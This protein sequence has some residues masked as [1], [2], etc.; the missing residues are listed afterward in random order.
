MLVS[1]VVIQSNSLELWGEFT[2]ALVTVNFLSV[3]LAFGNKDYLVRAFSKHP[4]T[5]KSQWNKIF[6]S[7]IPILIF[8]VTCLYFLTYDTSL[9][10]ICAVWLTLNFIQQS[11]DS[12]VLF[13]KN[14]R[15]TLLIELLCSILLLGFL[16]YFGNKITL[17]LLLL[18]YAGAQVIRTLLLLGMYWAHLDFPRSSSFSLAELKLLTPFFLLGLGGFLV[19]KADL[20]CVSIFLPHSEKASYQII[21]NLCN[22]GIVAASMVLVPFTKNI[23]RINAATFNVLHRNFNFFGALYSLSFM[24]GVYVLCNLLFKIEFTVWV[25]FGFLIN[26]FAFTLFLPYMFLFTK[27]N[28]QSQAVYLMLASGVFTFLLSALL[29]PKFNQEGAATAC[30]LGQIAL[31]LSTRFVA[32]H[33][34]NKS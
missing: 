20:L 10:L 28:W 24:L 3:L 19:D 29:V 31:L 34:K 17:Q 11:F 33:L 22:M 12:L 7:R 2:E 5:L 4:S 26:I 18:S 6:W 14:F 13:F 30:A 15:Q 23:Y 27:H 25:Y 32:Q 21:S 9:F 16:I 1:L 8:A